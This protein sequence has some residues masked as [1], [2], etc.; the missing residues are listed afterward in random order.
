MQHFY[1]N[2]AGWSSM[3]DQ[4][5]L[6]KLILTKIDLKN[7]IK[8]LELGVYQGRLTALWNVE[9]TNLGINYDYYA[10][11][12]FL[13]SE[14]HSKEVDYYNITLANLAPFVEKIKIIKND[15][16]IES[17]NYQDEYFDIVYI[18][19]SHDYES[20]KKDILHW[21]PKVKK[22]GIICGDDYVAGWPGVVKAVNEVFNN[23]VNIIGNQQW[24]VQ[25][26]Y[27]TLLVCISFHYVPEKLQY[28]KSIIN[29]FCNYPMHVDIIVDSNVYFELEG[30]TLIVND[31]LNHPYDLTWMHRKHIKNN[32]DAYDYFM[33]VEDDMDI[34]F[35]NFKNYITSFSKL[36]TQGFVPSFIRIEKF[37][38]NEYVVD[39]TD[40]QC[41][42]KIFK[43]D[44]TDYIVLSQ[45]YHAFWI[46]PN[47]ELK[48]TLIP[49]FLNIGG[50]REEAAWYPGHRLSKK[51]VVLVQNG[52]VSP[53]CYSYHLSN[54]YSSFPP[55][56]FGKIQA[57]KI[58]TICK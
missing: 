30:V 13:G 39:V 37:N 55:T 29:R 32:I 19:A 25:K 53:L 50:T 44:N 23:K 8:I 51:Q 41:S 26:K 58:I 42:N 47:K 4:G 1:E 6:L 28:L 49:D 45:P 12:H 31:N 2:I 33:Y 40:Q 14:E 20:V 27:N 17:K 38:G 48:E 3:S 9:L 54:N 21:L 5:E 56:P 36:W 43:I 22:D 7:K 57:D 52:Q 16:L 34:P 35:E 18:D 15:S 46:L 10:L 11:D 24:W